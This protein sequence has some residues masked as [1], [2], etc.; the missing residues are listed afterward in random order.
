MQSLVPALGRLGCKSSQTSQQT[1]R[2]SESVNGD[3]SNKENDDDPL[4]LFK[5]EN[6]VDIF[7]SAHQFDELEPPPPPPPPS[8]KLQSRQ[9]SDKSRT[10]SLYSYD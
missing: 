7:A 1:Q 8:S 3:R 6:D 9:S 10:E 2:N 4:L 5:D